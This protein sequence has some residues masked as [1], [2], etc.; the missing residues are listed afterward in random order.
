MIRS[1]IRP[2]LSALLSRHQRRG[3]PDSLLGLVLTTEPE[4]QLAPPR[5]ESQGLPADG[6]R[7]FV[8]NELRLSGWA[9][10]ATG[11]A[12]V[13]AE[14][15]RQS[16]PVV[17]GIES[18]DAVE[19]RPHIAG[20]ERAGFE[21]R[22]DTSEWERGERQIR[23]VARDG[24]GRETSRNGV[25]DVLPHQIASYMLR[26]IAADA[27][28]GRPVLR[29]DQPRLDGSNE[30]GDRLAVR[31]FAYAPSGIEAVLVSLDGRWRKPAE[32]GRGRPALIK[33]VH[34]DAGN[35]GFELHVDIGDVEDG[36]HCLSVIALARDGQAVGREGFFRKR[37]RQRPQ[38]RRVGPDG[39][40]IA[41]ERFVPEE[42]RRHLIDAE[43][44]A[45][46]RWAARVA[47]DAEV[48]DAACGT[49]SGTAI[50]AKA[51]AR[52]VVGL[53]RDA[54]S[55]LNARERV[56]DVA[57][58]MLGDL[59]EVAFDE[60]SFDLVTCFE[61]IEHVVEQ[62]AVLDELRRVLR[63]DG[64]LLI[65]SQNSDTFSPS[66]P[67]PL[68]EYTPGELR[69]ALGR[70]F[71]H[72][73]LYSQHAHLASVVAGD[74]V[75]AAESGYAPMP[76]E[77][78]GLSAAPAELYTVAAASDAELPVLDDIVTVGGVFE[79]RQLL[80][81]MWAW[82]D[83]ALAAEADAAASRTERDVANHARKRAE[84]LAQEGK[85]ARAQLDALR[86]SKSWTV[87][88]PLRR[89]GEVV[90]RRRLR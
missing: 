87:T 3:R 35:A 45:R 7:Y 89:M 86:T 38:S 19:A 37:H 30:V 61:A 54:K 17:T 2:P 47:P 49:G 18:R 20:A 79:V 34:P 46:Y 82:E 76:A 56:G 12:Q 43:H 10:S 29:C 88:A 74:E 78:R 16:V 60:G 81:S 44:Q 66:Q 80:E 64:T 53:D 85:R 36:M 55:I 28:A 26:T 31:G 25:L 21:I 70:R 13:T 72:V 11:P 83:Q 75:L 8:G 40:P 23:I 27:A 77:V 39:K 63:Q 57:E 41:R 71:A 59:R 73:R 32:Y 69:T 50:L 4:P 14:I 51:S 42:F 62:D 15:D 1:S 48:L 58:F 67:H 90:R 65:S 5:L 33:R 6:A 68:Q 24:A 52:R 84:E 9:L 22:V